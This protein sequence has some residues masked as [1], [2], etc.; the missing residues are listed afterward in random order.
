MNATTTMGD[1]GGKP[2]ELARSKK[3]GG[4]KFT[5]NLNIG[6]RLILGF[7]A[8]TLILVA[9]V[10]ITVVEVSG[11]A[12]K[13]ERIAKLRVPT[14]TAS[15]G[16]INNIN[17]SLA[18]LRGWMLT[19]NKGFKT[20]REA[21]WADIARLSGDIDRL[22]A[23]WTNQANVQKWARF[24][25]ILKE[26]A[27]AQAKVEAIANS[28]AQYPATVI[29]INEAAPQAA[30][31]IKTITQMIDTEATLEATPQRKAMLG[32]MADV[33][34][35]TGLALANIRAFL[36]TGDAKFQKNFDRFWAKNTRRFAD[37]QGQS[38]LLNTAQ[39]AAFAKFSKAR[40]A[41]SPLPP[42]M[43][44][45]RGS[46][47]WNMANYTLVK[48]AAPRAGKLLTIL[49]GPAKADGS[50][51]GG[52]VANQRRLLDKDA[53]A[54]ANDID[55]LEMIEWLLLAVGL[56][57]SAIIVFLLTRAIVGPVVS[58]TAAMRRLAHGDNEVDIPALDRRDELGEMAKS[59]QVFKD[60]AIEK[61]R[62]EAEQKEDEA[63]K[64]ERVR[65]LDELTKEFEVSVG[66]V[67]ESVSSASSQLKNTA[68]SMSS[69]AEETTRQSQAV[70]AAS[71]EAT[72]NVQTVAA[73]AE[74]M[75]NTVSEI[76][77]Q[78]TQ[79][80]EISNR[81][82][83]E[84]RKTNEAVDGLTAAAMRIS[85]VV[86]LISEIAEQTN[87]LALNATIESARAGEAGKGFA[88]V[89][90]E[91]KSLA[92][93]TAKATEDI[94]QQVNSIQDETKG[95]AD[96]IKS[97]GNTIGEISEIANVIASA[98]EEQ[99]AATQEIARNCQEAAKGNEEVAGNINGVSK[100]S[101]DTGAAA[102]QVLSTV[103]ELSA[104][105]D[106][107]SGTVKGFLENV[108]AA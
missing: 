39:S 50:R 28:P 76:S 107:L 22:S 77:R 83:E 30:V 7:A 90:N 2:S 33:R 87:L 97:I 47:R 41:F 106:T 95:A 31:M 67:V 21:V 64:T 15:A 27:A 88:V 29:L 92:E 94:E 62:L 60:N 55:R 81:A 32:M 68:E 5:A 23:N 99:S 49:A 57:L 82:V 14:A 96:A 37:L 101:I 34:G 40:A 36:L 66:T 53:T 79:S 12:T 104:Q 91:V 93:Q 80:S 51:S 86:R 43:F 19:G 3:G 59:V 16:I 17:A 46:N 20:Q 26:F 9:A 103:V 74:E 10:G 70:A 52:M 54:T 8:V 63:K 6:R 25:T 4:F 42:R 75:S 102:N 24:K 61:I 69:T 72:S 71:E 18:S 100:A 44:E 35:T 56:L 65:R 89:A 84:A 105:S 58:M 11:I 45:V 85:E 108:N 48:E 13:S 38:G 78:V 98:V 1:I 73:A